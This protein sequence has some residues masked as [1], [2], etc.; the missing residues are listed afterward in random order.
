MN[1]FGVDV[2]KFLFYLTVEEVSY[3][4]SR[5]GSTYSVKV[6]LQLVNQLDILEKRSK[7]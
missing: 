2:V 6:V 7:T 4:K 5:E 3:T 1:L